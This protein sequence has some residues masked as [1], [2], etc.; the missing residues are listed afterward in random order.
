MQKSIQSRSNYSQDRRVG[1]VMRVIQGESTKSIAASYG[2]TPHAI[3][4]AK[5]SKWFKA[6]YDEMLPIYKEKKHKEI[7]KMIEKLHDLADLDNYK[8]S[9]KEV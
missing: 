2:V 9:L 8:K 4:S 5:K 6:L 7:E 1:I 3:Y